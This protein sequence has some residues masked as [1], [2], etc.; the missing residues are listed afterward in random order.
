MLVPCPRC[1]SPNANDRNTGYN[2]PPPEAIAA[3]E[4][5]KPAQAAE[6]QKLPGPI[7]TMEGQICK[8]HAD[9]LVV[10]KERGEL[11]EKLIWR[12]ILIC[13]N[14]KVSLGTAP[15]AQQ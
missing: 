10:A 8:S 4:A 15:E 14:C 13:E 1:G 2:L 7:P 9:A 11:A 5:K 12:E 3:A 6:L